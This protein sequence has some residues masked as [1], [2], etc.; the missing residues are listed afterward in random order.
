MPLLPGRVA[1]MRSP[2]VLFIV[3][4]S[5][6]AAAQARG[7]LDL[8]NAPVPAG[9]QHIAY[10]TDPLQFGELRVPATPGP[11]PWPQVMGSV[12]RL[13]SLRE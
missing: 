1:A 2:A 6:V 13:L 9:A 12:R 11:H 10:G 8:A 5:G 3:L 7:P 4:C